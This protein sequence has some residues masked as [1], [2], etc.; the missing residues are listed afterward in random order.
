MN[1]ISNKTVKFSMQLV[2]TCDAT[3]RRNTAKCHKLLML[4]GNEWTQVEHLL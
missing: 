2:T 3:E 4:N 1:I